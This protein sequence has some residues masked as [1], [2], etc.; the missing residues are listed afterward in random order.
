[1]SS[2]VEIEYL[3][4]KHLATVSSIDESQLM[5]LVRE[6]LKAAA[7]AGSTI[8]SPIGRPGE[9]ISGAVDIL[10]DWVWRGILKTEGE[11]STGIRFRVIST[12]AL[13]LIAQK[14]KGEDQ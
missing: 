12:K 5:E 11:I 2:H 9:R 10:R 4:A 6:D 13:Q 8:D 3:L 1:M 7:M 14:F